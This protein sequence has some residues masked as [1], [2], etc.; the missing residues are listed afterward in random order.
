MTAENFNI[1]LSLNELN[2]VLA[3]LGK[4]P[5]ESV[6]IVIEKIQKQAQAQST[7]SSMEK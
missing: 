5:Y 1:Q 6:Y 4:Q 7:N 2:T 3:Y